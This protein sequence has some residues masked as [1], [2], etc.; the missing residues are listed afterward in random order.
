MNENWTVTTFLLALSGIIVL[1]ML[2]GLIAQKTWLKNVPPEELRRRASD[3][4]LRRQRIKFTSAAMTL[5]GVLLAWWAFPAVAAYN[6]E[7]EILQVTD[8]QLFTG[9]MAVFCCVIFLIAAIR[10]F[11]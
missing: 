9:L 3:T 7:Y 8:R 6:R 2:L 5:A 4:F 1:A 11:R 10:K